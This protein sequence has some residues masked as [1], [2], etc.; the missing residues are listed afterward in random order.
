MTNVS[1]RRPAT[2]PKD[3]R[4]YDAGKPWLEIDLLDLKES[5][6]EGATV[7]QAAGQLLRTKVEVREKMRELGLRAS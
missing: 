4:L 2:A 6:K 3:D 5:L 1:T 7:E